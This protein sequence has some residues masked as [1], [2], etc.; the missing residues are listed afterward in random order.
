MP[1][2]M[3]GF[4]RQLVPA[5]YAQMRAAIHHFWAGELS[6]SELCSVCC[7]CGMLVHK[8]QELAEELG[9]ARWYRD[10]EEE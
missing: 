3:P 8:A 2:L 6:P 1:R 4:S 9:D 7:Q 5:D 10:S